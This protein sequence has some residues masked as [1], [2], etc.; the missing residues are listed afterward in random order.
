CFG[1]GARVGRGLWRNAERLGDE[2]A[3]G[4]E[5]HLAGRRLPPG[6]PDGAAGLRRRK[7]QE[8]DALVAYLDVDSHLRHQRHTVTV[9]YH[10]QHG[11]KAS[12]AK[13]HSAG[14]GAV[15]AIV[16]RLVA[17]AMSLLEQDQ[18]PMVDVLDIHARRLW[19]RIVGGNRQQKR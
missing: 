6:K 3:E 12:R 10:L 8:L 16:E 4:Y 18:P 13:S 2:L 9:C 19:V 7:A 5:I 1:L 14:G 17:Q 11:R 15:A